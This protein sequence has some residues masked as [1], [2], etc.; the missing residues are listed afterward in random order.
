MSKKTHETGSG[1]HA[2]PISKKS[3]KDSLR[4]KCLGSLI[5]VIVMV[6]GCSDNTDLPRNTQ[7]V[8][9]MKIELGVMPAELVKGHATAPGDPNA[10][11]GG[12]PPNS[13]SNHIVVALFDAKTGARVTDARIRAGVGDRWYNHEPDKPL[14]PMEINGA[15][16]Y[17]NFFLMQGSGVWRIHLVI[18]RPGMTRPAEADFGY[19]HASR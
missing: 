19:E 1:T 17:G 12:T 3:C 9:G 2:P 14:E 8:D 10:M 16:S 5:A 7:I 15:L 4:C 18:H 6:S 11:H 13:R